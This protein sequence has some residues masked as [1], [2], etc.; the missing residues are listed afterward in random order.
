MAGGTPDLAAGREGE[1]HGIFTYYVVKGLEGEADENADGIV[2]ADELVEYVHQNVRQVTNAQQN[3]TS[4][5]GSFDPNLGLS[6]NPKKLAQRASSA[7]KSEFG[8][9]I[10]EAN[11]D[12]VEVFVD[13]KSAGV[14]NK[15]TALKLQGLRPGVHTIKAVEM[16]YEPDGPREEVVYPGE[17]TSV[18]IK[19]LIPRRRS[20]AAADLL[21]KGLEY[22]DKG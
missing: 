1:G 14:I 20:K 3:P 21:D 6:Y 8:T 22:Y 19:I 17:Q 16:G 12:G 5:R 18:S 13:G 9:L 11:L 7:S 10:L 4:D 15:G 2:T